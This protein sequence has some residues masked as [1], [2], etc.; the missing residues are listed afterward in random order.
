M[1]S[2]ELTG[3][4]RH[5][6]AILSIRFDVFVK[7]Q[8]VDPSLEID[9][10][11][12]DCLHAIAYIDGKAVGTGRLLPDGHIGRMAVLTDYRSRGIGSAI[13]RALIKAA[14]DRGDTLVVLATNMPPLSPAI[15]FILTAIPLLRLE[16]AYSCSLSEVPRPFPIIETPWNQFHPI[17]QSGLPKNRLLI[18]FLRN[19]VEHLSD[20]IGVYEISFVETVSRDQTS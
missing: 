7:E 1:V 2:V 19:V 6:E 9:G 10:Q 11:D 17:A 16:R 4:S 13:F 18:D 12:P 5:Q 14:R 15:G 20:A 8:G 3:F